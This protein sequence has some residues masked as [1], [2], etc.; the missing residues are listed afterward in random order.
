M[1]VYALRLPPRE[2]CSLLAKWG[3]DENILLVDMLK[4]HQLHECLGE[5]I[6]LKS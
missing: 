5:M 6:Y 4:Q 2:L 1:R 3:L